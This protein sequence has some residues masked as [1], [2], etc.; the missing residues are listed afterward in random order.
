VWEKLPKKFLKE[1]GSMENLWQYRQGKDEKK[2]SKPTKKVFYQKLWQYLLDC[3]VV[4][5]KLIM[6]CQ[7]RYRKTDAFFNE[8]EFRRMAEQFDSIFKKEDRN[9]KQAC[10]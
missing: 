2:I 9:S 10:I 1:Y 5:M 7:L 6:N 3:P 8:L 4:S